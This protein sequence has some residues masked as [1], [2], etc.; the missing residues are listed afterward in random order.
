MTIA[1]LRRSGGSLTVTVPVEYR[2]AHDL[3]EG[4]EMDVQISDDKLIIQPARSK[5]TLQAIIE[6]APK[7]PASLRA[8]DWDE[9]PVIGKEQ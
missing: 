5:I 3:Q 8:T 6:S 4:Q 1:R 2:R 7:D 9:I